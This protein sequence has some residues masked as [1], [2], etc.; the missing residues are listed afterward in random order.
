[1][2]G[3]VR[4]CFGLN[5]GEIFRP[6]GCAHYGQTG[7]RS[8]VA[9]FELLEIDDEIRELMLLRKSASA[10]TAAGVAKGMRLLRDDGLAKVRD[11][12][13]SLDEV[14]RVAGGGGLEGVG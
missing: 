1:M 9:I 14:I 5:G 8:R 2:P 6:K 12:M 3:G 13:T 10:L 4:Q 11:G 7:Y